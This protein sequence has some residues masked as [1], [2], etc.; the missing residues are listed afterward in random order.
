MMEMSNNMI[1]IMKNNIDLI[2]EFDSIIGVNP[3]IV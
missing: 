3:P 1:R 2:E